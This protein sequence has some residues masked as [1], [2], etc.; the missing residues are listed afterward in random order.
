MQSLQRAELGGDLQLV[1]DDLLTMPA[2]VI[3]AKHG[4]QKYC[5]RLEQRRQRAADVV[6]DASLGREF[7][8]GGSATRSPAIHSCALTRVVT[9]IRA[10]D[11]GMARAFTRA[12]RLPQRLHNGHAGRR[13]AVALRSN[14]ISLTCSAFQD[15]AARQRQLELVEQPHEAL[16]R[17]PRV[18]ARATGEIAPVLHR[19]KW[20]RP[21]SVERQRLAMRTAATCDYVARCCAHRKVAQRPKEFLPAQS[22]A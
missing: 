10:S 16:K 2:V 17:H 12:G 18:V 19:K 21:L 20:N 4:T 3:S 5:A 1:H 11:E 15:A 22:A 6:V 9:D 13:R 8:D 7:H 14:E